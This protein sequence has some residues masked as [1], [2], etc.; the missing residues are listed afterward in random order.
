MTMP[1]KPTMRG[2]IVAARIYPGAQRIERS[3]ARR[4]QP[5]LRSGV[6][7]NSSRSA[8]VI[9]RAAPSIAFKRHIAG[10]SVGD[11]DVDLVGKNIVALDEADVVDVARRP[12]NCARP[13]RYRCP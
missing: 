2:A 3:A 11:D 13:A 4:A 1:F 9:K 10:E 5:S 12:A 8:S 7:V 6:R